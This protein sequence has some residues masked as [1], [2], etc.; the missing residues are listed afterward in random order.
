MGNACQPTTFSIAKDGKYHD[1]TY[2][3][4][5]DVVSVLYWGPDGVTRREAHAENPVQ[6]EQT[7]CKL[8]Q[9]MI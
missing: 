3:V 5:G 9:Q 8:L 4:Q 1:A 7:A 2:M 6:P